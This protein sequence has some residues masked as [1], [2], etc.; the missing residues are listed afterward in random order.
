[1]NIAI[2][3][4]HTE[5]LIA[6][7]F[8]AFC[9]PSK[10]TLRRGAVE[11]CEKWLRSGTVDVALLPTLSILRD[12]DAFDV[13]PAVAVS[14]WGTPFASLVSRKNIGEP[15][16]AFSVHPRYAQE[17][18]VARIILKEHYGIIPKLIPVSHTNMADLLAENTDAA[19][20]MDQLDS[21]V[22]GSLNVLDLGQEWYELVN[23][24]MV[25][26]LFAMRK[27]E[28][29]VTTAIQ[30]RDAVS[31]ADA[32]RAHFV[33]AAKGRPDLEAY[34][35]ENLRLRFDRLAVASLTAF[36]EYIYYFGVTADIPDLPLY[37]IP[38]NA[39]NDDEQPL[40]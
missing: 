26:G 8:E 35:E 25:W 16:N 1:M 32:G 18:L 19:L 6:S 14:S 33:R 34:Y 31:V 30:V 15:I 9:D 22:D 7:G 40:L 39:D 12:E 2:W 5:A 23:Y 24:P 36:R 10:L 38:E 29:D 27:G 28:A 21:P 17:A 13:L 3:N 37:E 11:E 20:V 4:D